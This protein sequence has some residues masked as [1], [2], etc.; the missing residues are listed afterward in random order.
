MASDAGLRRETQAWR[1][2]LH[3]H[4]KFAFGIRSLSL[5][6]GE[7]VS[8]GASASGAVLGGLFRGC[9]RAC[10]TPTLISRPKGSESSR[11]RW[12]AVAR[13]AELTAA[14]PVDRRS[15]GVRPERPGAARV[16]P[17]R[18]VPAGKSGA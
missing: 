1:H 8:V 9:A 2:D 15:V 11:W 16:V 6:D 12:R 5:I 14:A 3:T 10:R 17:A 7:R 4:P 13:A 18:I